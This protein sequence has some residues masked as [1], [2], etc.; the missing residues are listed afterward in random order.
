MRQ[1]LLAQQLGLASP[2]PGSRQDPQSPR[3]PQG[4]GSPSVRPRAPWRTEP[5][6][7]MMPST[8]EPSSPWMVGRGPSTPKGRTPQPR[9]PDR[10][11]GTP[12][13]AG[14][15]LERG[16]ITSK[17]REKQ[18]QT[19]LS[20]IVTVVDQVDMS[21]AQVPGLMC[22]LLPHQVQGIE[23]MQKREQGDI[24]G[25]ILADDMG[26]GKVGSRGAHLDGP[27]ACLDHV[28]PEPGQN[29][30]RGWL[31]GS[32]VEPRERRTRQDPKEETAHGKCC[33][34]SRWRGLCRRSRGLPR[35]A[36]ACRVFFSH[37]DNPD[38]CAPGCR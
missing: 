30:R 33:G 28:P 37:K 38:C 17:E 16:Q 21:K 19:M 1:R 27:N 34:R 2:T 5:K 29:Q 20:S 36:T 14:T 32:R 18:L 13:S 25:G 35:A 9:T 22:R 24:K 10:G 11:F 23:W 8:P 7:R 3:T 31:W 4:T 26:L 12:N 15:P 6:V